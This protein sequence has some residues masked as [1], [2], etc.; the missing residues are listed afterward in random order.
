MATSLERGYVCS[1]FRSTNPVIA[2]ERSFRGKFRENYL[3][4][5]S[6]SFLWMSPYSTAMS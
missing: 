3:R 5:N 4:A 1:A 6:V 2:F